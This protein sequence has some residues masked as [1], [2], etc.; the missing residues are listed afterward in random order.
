MAMLTIIT[1]GIIICIFP[2]AGL[3]LSVIAWAIFSVDWN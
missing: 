2:P 1:C 3:I